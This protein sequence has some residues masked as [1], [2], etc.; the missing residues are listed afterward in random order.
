M[1]AKLEIVA[2]VLT[3]AAVG[4]VFFFLGRYMN[5]VVFV[6]LLAY[7]ALQAVRN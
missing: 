6:M 5:I 1:R 3:L 2:W 4:T 7:L